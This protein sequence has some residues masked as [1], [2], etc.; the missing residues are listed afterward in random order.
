MNL[1]P[2]RLGSRSASSRRW[3]LAGLAA[4]SLAL[5]GVACGDDEPSEEDL[6]QVEDTATRALQATPDDAEFF[7]D[8]VTDNLIETVLFSSREDCSANPGE[9]IGEPA[10]VQG[11]KD[12]TIDGDKASTTVTAD[13]GTFVLD[14]VKDGGDWKVDAMKATSDEVPD[15]AKVVDMSLK[16]FAFE[17][18]A[19]DI[20][21]NGNVAF[22]LKN[23]GK[24]AHEVIVFSLPAD[25]TIEEALEN[26]EQSGPPAGM[27]VF[28]QPGQEVD[29]AF[30]QPLA[31]GRYALLCFFPDTSDPEGTPHMAKGMVSEFS[32]R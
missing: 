16:D 8:H 2:T 19:A 3:L 27:K 31:A 13:F 23:D 30:A 32:V 1:N 29:M 9:C 6:R 28:V 5:A 11:V 14:L 20:P 12:T 4:T 26:A 24:Q 25:G 15:G 17:F 22:R 18:K 21:S 10:T 7:F